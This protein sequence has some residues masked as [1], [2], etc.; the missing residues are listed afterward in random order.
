MNAIDLELNRL[1]SELN[2]VKEAEMNYMMRKGQFE[3]GVKKLL[4][5]LGVPENF[6]LIQIMKIAREK[7]STLIEAP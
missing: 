3:E 6:N 2:A 7:K 4:R 1:E 5:D